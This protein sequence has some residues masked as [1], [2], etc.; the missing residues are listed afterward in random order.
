MSEP[1]NAQPET[2]SQVKLPAPSEVPTIIVEKTDSQPVH[3]DDFGEK[4]TSTQKAAHELRAADASPDKIVVP[5]EAHETSVTGELETAPLFGHEN[6]PNNSSTHQSTSR[7]TTNLSSNHGELND[8]GGGQSSS[9]VDT[10]LLFSYEAGEDGDNDSYDELSHGPLLSHET[11]LNGG[12]AGHVAT[13]DEGELDAAPLLPHETGFAQHHEDGV[14]TNSSSTTGEDGSEPRHYAYDD[15]DELDEQLSFGRRNSTNGDPGYDENDVPLL[16]HERD[17]AVIS[18]S[19]SELGE[20]GALTSPRYSTIE[21]ESGSAKELFG[22]PPMFRAR[23]NS[24]T[25]PHKLPRSDAE[26]E[27][28]LD[29]SLERFPTDREQILQRVATIGLHLPEDQTLEDSVHSPVLS[30]LSQAC[31]SV[32]LVPVKSYASLASVP[33][34]DNSD[35]DEEDDADAESLSS[36]IAL[37]TR[38][39]T[40]SARSHPEELD[41][42]KTQV[43]ETESAERAKKS[44]DVDLSELKGDS[45]P[46][47]DTSNLSTSASA[48]LDQSNP[49]TVGS[50][51]QPEAQKYQASKEEKDHGSPAVPLTSEKGA[52]D[53]KVTR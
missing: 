48:M 53:N 11:G 50:T 47:S 44:K 49:S 36:P 6:E 12:I 10:G 16:P 24:S 14:T 52:A 39:V 29:P 9:Y 15:D 37:N 1:E 5:A 33:E 3:G 30:V 34:A 23:T 2:S 17:S 13:E 28:L 46:V 38:R 8:S 41:A 43:S 27:N 20:E 7:D 21:G 35:E 51:S 19:G 42:L 22:R 32:D 4:A 31:S 26:D 45:A 18:Q 40:G 25:L